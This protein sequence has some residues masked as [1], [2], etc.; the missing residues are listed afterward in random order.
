[1]LRNVVREAGL[2]EMIIGAGQAP[3]DKDEVGWWAGKQY[4]WTGLYCAVD[5]DDP[6]YTGQVLLAGGESIIKPISTERAQRYIRSYLLLS[7][8]R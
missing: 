1:M 6:E 7:T 4:N 5:H 8:S 2:G 3:D